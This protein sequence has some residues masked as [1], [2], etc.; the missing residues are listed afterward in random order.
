MNLTQCKIF[1]PFFK[2]DYWTEK[3]SRLWFFL[4]SW[5]TTR[6]STSKFRNRPMLFRKNESPATLPIWV[7]ANMPGSKEA[8]AVP[9]PIGISKKFM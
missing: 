7:C 3:A 9:L 2:N 5:K 4:E 1:N 6:L 8:K